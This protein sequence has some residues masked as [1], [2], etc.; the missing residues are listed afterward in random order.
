MCAHTNY[1]VKCTF[2][3]ILQIFSTLFF[4]NF[5]T[6]INTELGSER[7]T[8]GRMEEALP[9]LHSTA[10]YREAGKEKERVGKPI[11]SLVL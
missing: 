3:W 1:I 11:R 9:Y 8:Q 10:Q 4:H 6:N 5:E 2:F 7:V